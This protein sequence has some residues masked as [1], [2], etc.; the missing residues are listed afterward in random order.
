MEVRAQHKL[1]AQAESA[2]TI[3]FA[4]SGKFPTLD[5]SAVRHFKV[6]P[7]PKSGVR[8]ASRTALRYLRNVFIAE[9]RSSR[10]V[11]LLNSPGAKYPLWTPSVEAEVWS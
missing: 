2:H 1:A 10:P 6:C 8:C 7:R 3:F 4:H 9:W 5:P 11:A